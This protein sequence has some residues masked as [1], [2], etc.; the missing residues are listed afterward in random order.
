MPCS[1]RNPLGPS[2][3]V[4]SPAMFVCMNVFTSSMLRVCPRTQI[5]FVYAAEGSMLPPSITPRASMS[6]PVSYTR[7]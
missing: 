5:S 7:R 6:L 2:R 1:S 4:I 3:S